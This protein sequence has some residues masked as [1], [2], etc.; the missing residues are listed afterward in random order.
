[1]YLWIITHL[2]Q[3][4]KTQWKDAKIFWF[5]DETDSKR[6]MRQSIINKNKTFDCKENI[7]KN[8]NKVV[9]TFSKTTN[10][11]IYEEKHTKNRA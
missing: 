11:I 8:G 7:C 2:P 6:S 3:G 5:D 9:V 4:L 1:M 10:M